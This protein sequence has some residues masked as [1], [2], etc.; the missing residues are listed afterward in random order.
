MPVFSGLPLLKG[1]KSLKLRKQTFRID[2]CLYYAT[3]DHKS[4]LVICA[5]FLPINNF[6]KLIRLC[7]FIPLQPP[8]KKINIPKNTS[9]KKN[10]VISMVV[11]F[12]IGLFVS[13][14]SGNK[15]ADLKTKNDSIAYVIGANIGQNLNENIKRDSLE[16][17]TEALVQGFKDAINGLDTSVF[18][19]AQK[20]AIMVEFQK[21][22]QQKQ[23]KKQAEAAIPNKEEGAKFLEENKKKEGIITTASGLQ[24]K[25]VKMGKGAQ[26]KSTDKVTVNYEGKLLSGKVFDSSFD[27]KQPASFQLSN[28]IQGWQE[29]L[30]LMKEGSTFE[31]Y[32]PSSIGY[33]DQ[34]YPPDIPGGSTLIFKVD[35]IKVEAAPAQ[36]QQQAQQPKK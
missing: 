6:L 36:D 4:T 34:G 16:L 8:N 27:R 23:M 12:I 33:G 32:I 17:P 29:G 11:V 24:Y 25:V 26:P 2:P 31:L 18:T 10:F 7:F 19:S 3:P 20:Q 28:V 13:C 14:D 35:L 30:M 5:C 22:M 9:M 21:E 15:T 1:K